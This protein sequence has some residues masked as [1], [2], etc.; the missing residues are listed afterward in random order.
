VRIEYRGKV[1]RR[2]KTVAVR[3]GVLTDVYRAQ[4]NQVNVRAGTVVKS[5][6]LRGSGTGSVT[7]G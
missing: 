5:M 7:I 2:V 3:S 1:P 6:T 4:V